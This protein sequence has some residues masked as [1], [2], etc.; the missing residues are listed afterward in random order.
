MPRYIHSMIRVLDEARALAFYDM[1]FGLRVAERLDFPDF[2]LIYLSNAE[3]EVELELT[4]NRGRTEPYD[5][6]DGYGHIAF[7]V[8]DIAAEH[9]R[10][11]TAGLNP[12][13]LVDFAPGGSVIARFFFVTDP[14]GYKIEVLQRGG[15]YL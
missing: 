4:V 5:L 13:K 7:S 10:F 11:T 3:S 2:S 9:A 15:R 1:A 14:D 6:G 8:E 12:G